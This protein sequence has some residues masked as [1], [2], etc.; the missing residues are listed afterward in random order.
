MEHAMLFRPA[1]LLDENRSAYMNTGALGSSKE[2]TLATG[3]AGA[4]ERR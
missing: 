2:K 3:G 1:E 4:E